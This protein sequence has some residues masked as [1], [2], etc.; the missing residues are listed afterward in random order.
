MKL[1]QKQL[2][3]KFKAIQKDAN[4]LFGDFGKKLLYG[5]ATHKDYLNYARRIRK[6]FLD[7]WRGMPE[8]LK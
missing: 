1:E 7:D 8:S 2:H 6:N 4:R 5:T 3:Q